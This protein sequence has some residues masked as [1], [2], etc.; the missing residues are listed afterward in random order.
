MAIPPA[1]P[2]QYFTPVF[3]KDMP[4]SL[5]THFRQIYLAM[6]QHDQAIKLVNAKVGT[7][8]ATTTISSSSSGGVTPA[9]TASF[10]GL[11][12]VNNQTGNVAYTTAVTDNGILLILSDASPV[13]VT[14]NSAVTSPFFLFATNLGAGTAILT[15]S[16]GTINGGAT[17]TILHNYTA[18]V[19]F[20]G[21]NW[22]ATAFP[23]IPTSIAHVAHEWLDSY[24]AATGL[25]T[26]SQPAFT[27][28]SGQITTAQLPASGISATITTAALTTLGTQGSMTFTNGILTAQTPAT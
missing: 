19:A 1:D 5:A 13:A 21:T 16:T 18:I 20:D 9:P 7:P 15:P 14:L 8:S 10:P 4:Q 12:G 24:N 22:W 26:Q 28:I 17:F 11:G 25:F 23:V 3:D 27:D 2:N 6:S